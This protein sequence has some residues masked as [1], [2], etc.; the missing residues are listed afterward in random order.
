MDNFGIWSVLP[1]VIAI[2][3][4]F[5]TRQVL[6][7][8]LVSIWIGA[9]I[10]SGGNP[11]AGFARTVQEYIAGSI[12]KPWNAS[13]ITYSLTLGGMIGVITKSGGMKAIADWLSSRARSAKSGQFATLLMGFIIFFDDYANTMLVGNTMRPLT[14]RLRISREKLSFICDSTAAPIA[15]IALISTWTAYEIGLIKGAFDTLNIQMNT[16]EAFIRSIPFR[17][18]SIIALFFVFMI[19]VLGRDF[20]PMLRAER[21]ARKS[22]KVIADG[23]APLATR[24]LTDME[25]KDGIPL[26]WYNAIIPVL[27]VVIMVIIGLFLHGYGEIV[28]GGDNRLAALVKDHPFSLISLREIIGSANAAVAM[29]WAA[30]AGTFTAFALVL[31]Q[32][33][34][35]L[36][37]AVTAWIDGA[38]SFLIAVMIL[39]LAWGIGSLC[40]D[41][42]TASYL[43]G[44]LEGRVWAGFIPIAVFMLG[45][46]I[47]FAT[48]TAYGTTAI[49]MPIAV[50]LCYHLSGGETGGLFFATIGAVFTGAV[51]GDHCSPLSD[52]TIMSSMACASDHIDHVKTQMPYAVTVAAIAVLAGFIPAAFSVNPFILIVTGMILAFAVVRFMGERVD[53]VLEDL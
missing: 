29:M 3:L 43:V 10:I 17:F 21:R 47:A 24:E 42:G 27:T 36:R 19:C 11:A 5:A 4:A 51:F 25:I 6:P 38:K 28:K 31:T 45:C 13:I 44:I 39:V 49:L 2:V 23:A 14:D 40:R 46:L 12:A 41:M 52:T 18:Y 7:S 32:R 30:F 50:P 15:S 37:E 26:R 22:G 33:I 35:T 8:L 16:Y 9:T 34:L 1:P 20:G 53:N 48:G